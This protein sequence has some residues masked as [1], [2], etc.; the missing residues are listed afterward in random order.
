MSAVRLDAQMLGKEMKRPDGFRPERVTS[1]SSRIARTMER[2]DKIFHEFLFLARPADEQPEEIN[3]SDAIRECVDTL[4]P[5][6][7]QAGVSPI[8]D[9]A[10]DLFAKAYSA[11]FRRALINVLVNA[12]QFSPKESAVKISLR[13]DGDKL[14]LAVHDDGPEIPHKEREKIFELFVT[15]RPEG[16]GLGLFLARTAIERCGG[17]IR[18]T[19]SEQGATIE[20]EL[21]KRECV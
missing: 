12:I 17:K 21:Q 13:S 1:L 7:E 4:S 5:R 6:F 8:L 11:A 14:R 18:V 19:D 9:V 20:I 2:M 16:T 3:I 15:G 10:D